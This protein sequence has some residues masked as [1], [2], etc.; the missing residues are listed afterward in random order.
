MPMKSKKKP[1]N[2]SVEQIKFI[3][4]KVHTLGTLFDVKEFYKRRDKVG[5]FARKYAKWVYRPGA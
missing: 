3:E 5:V 4:S 2:L 1:G